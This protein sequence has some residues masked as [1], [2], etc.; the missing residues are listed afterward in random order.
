MVDDASQSRGE[1]HITGSTMSQKASISRSYNESKHRMAYRYISS[2]HSWFYPEDLGKSP[3]KK[4]FQEK[5]VGVCVC[6]GGGGVCVCVHE[7][8]RACVQWCVSEREPST[9]KEN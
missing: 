6:G 3:K 7:C 2:L 5:K 8:V 1:Y 4:C 9:L